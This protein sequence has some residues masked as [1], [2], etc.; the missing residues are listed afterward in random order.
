VGGELRIEDNE[1]LEDLLG[2]EGLTAIGSTLTL[3][4]NRNLL[5]LSALS[6]VTSV[7]AAVLIS[8]NDLLYDLA[9]LEAISA[10][11][12]DFALKY[13][14]DLCQGYAVDFVADGG[15]GTGDV[16]GNTGDCSGYSGSP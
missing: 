4:A 6:S 1:R 14:A 5:D 12:G 9:G 10:I 8:Q 3:R 13:N 15:F 2:L 11:G 7:G 16:L